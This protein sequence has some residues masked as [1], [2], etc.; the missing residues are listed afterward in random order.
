MMIFLKKKNWTPKN[1]SGHKISENS[2]ILTFHHFQKLKNHTKK[3]VHFKLLTN[4]KRQ[5]QHLKY[6]YFPWK[7]KTIIFSNTH[8]F[9]SH[10]SF[11]LKKLNISVFICLRN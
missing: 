10:L 9:H 7:T 6:H 1:A 2:E 4:I 5:F 8:N 11:S 3:N